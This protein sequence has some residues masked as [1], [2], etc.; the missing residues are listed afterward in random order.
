MRSRRLPLR[1]GERVFVYD[2]PVGQGPAVVVGTLTNG[3]VLVESRA[4]GRCGNGLV[5]VPRLALTPPGTPSRDA[6]ERRLA[7]STSARA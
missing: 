6:E 2:H 4:C 3:D 1:A 7:G 5:V